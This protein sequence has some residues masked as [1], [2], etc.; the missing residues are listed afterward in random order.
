MYDYAIAYSVVAYTRLGLKAEE[1]M[2]HTFGMLRHMEVRP[3]RLASN[4]RSSKPRHKLC[5]DTVGI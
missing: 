3:P 2:K 5:Y 4:L 1:G